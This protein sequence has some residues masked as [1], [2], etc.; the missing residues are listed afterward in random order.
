M[1]LIESMMVPCTRMI[2]TAEEDGLFGRQ[3][4][5]MPGEPFRA[6]IL[7]QATAEGT[8]AEQPVLNEP[9]TVV[10]PAGVALEHHEIFRRD[11]DGALFRVTGNPRDAEAPAQSTVQISKTTAERWEADGQ[12][13]IGA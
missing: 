9:Y 10:L 1:S 12:C 7:K 13:D 4:A 5:Y 6:A 2:R 3:S 11:A 8:R